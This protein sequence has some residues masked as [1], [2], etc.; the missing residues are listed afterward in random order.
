MLISSHG[1]N[2]LYRDWTLYPQ[3]VARLW[4][5]YG[6]ATI[7]LF[8]SQENAWCPLYF[9]L[10]DENA[11]LGVDALGNQWPNVLLYAFPPLSLINPT[12]AR[13]KEQA[14]GSGNC[15][16]AGESSVALAATEGCPV[17]S[18]RGNLSPSSGQTGFLGLACERW[19]LNAAGLPPAVIETIQGDRASSAQAFCDCKWRIFEEWCAQKV[20]GGRAPLLSARFCCFVCLLLWARPFLQ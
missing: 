13:V 9:S 5:R 2:P 8:A 17:P 3:V 7:N 10:A 4:Q 6:Q 15:S 19:N 20:L 11:P 14:L 18:E 16:A 12:L 1:E